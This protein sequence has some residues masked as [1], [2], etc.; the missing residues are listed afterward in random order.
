MPVA[1][2]GV[3]KAER[4]DEVGETAAEEVVVRQA[5]SVIGLAFV[6]AGRVASVGSAEGIDEVRRAGAESVGGIG[7]T[8]RTAGMARAAPAALEYAVTRP[9]EEPMRIVDATE[10]LGGHARTVVNIDD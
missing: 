10:V 7:L 2:A 4:A 6:D 5:E 8:E 3:E 1:E 9:V